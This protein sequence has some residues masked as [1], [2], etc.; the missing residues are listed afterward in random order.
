M[1]LWY[2]FDTI[3]SIVWGLLLHCVSTS[4]FNSSHTHK[5][6]RKQAQSSFEKHKLF[7]YHT[8]WLIPRIY[9]CFTLN[10]C[11]W[12]H[13]YSI[14]SMCIINGNTSSLPSSS[15]HGNSM[16]DNVRWYWTKTR[17]GLLQKNINS[18]VSMASTSTENV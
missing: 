14:W 8:L 11:T 4:E 9:F 2:S 12:V 16:F 7:M 18:K 6:R 10:V 17:L 1:G 5:E 13:H 3:N 15:W